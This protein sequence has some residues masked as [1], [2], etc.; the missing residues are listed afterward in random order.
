MHK[1]SRKQLSGHAN[2]DSQCALVAL[3]Q[4]HILTAAKES[5]PQNN[6]RYAVKQNDVEALRWFLAQEI[7][8]PA[9]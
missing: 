8:A 7:K 9:I 5:V 3:Q 2:R 4:S 1:K 6:Q